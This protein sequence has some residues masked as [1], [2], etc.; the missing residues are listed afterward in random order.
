MLLYPVSLR[1]KLDAVKCL[2]TVGH[3]TCDATYF[4]LV[5]M[6]Q[7]CQYGLSESVRNAIQCKAYE[8]FTYRHGSK[9]PKRMKI[10]SEITLK[11]QIINDFEKKNLNES[12]LNSIHQY[13]WILETFK[14]VDGL[15]MEESVY[16]GGGNKF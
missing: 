10:R 3:Y 5:P 15:V 14:N 16:S 7:E 4:E 6:N 12:I 13:S 9:W 11:T 8:L 2:T 1:A